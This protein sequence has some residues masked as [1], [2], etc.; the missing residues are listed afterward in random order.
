MAHVLSAFLLL[1][2]GCVGVHVVRRLSRF[3]RAALLALLLL[4]AVTAPPSEHHQTEVANAITR[5][6][7]GV[8]SSFAARAG[9]AAGVS[10]QLESWDLY[11]CSLS[12]LHGRVVGVG[13][14]GQVFLFDSVHKVG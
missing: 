12:T 5:G 9:S 11:L 3:D 7:P 4:A 6:V 1:V 2:L 14:F 13:V 10:A 8:V